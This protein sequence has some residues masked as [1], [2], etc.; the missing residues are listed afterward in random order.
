MITKQEAAKCVAAISE[1]FDEANKLYDSMRDAYR[2][3]VGGRVK[4]IYEKGVTD[5]EMYNSLAGLSLGSFAQCY[6]LEGKTVIHLRSNNDVN[7]WLF[8]NGDIKF[9]VRWGYG[10]NDLSIDSVIPIDGVIY[11][12]RVSFIERTFN[13][14]LTSEATRKPSD[15]EKLVL[16]LDRVNRFHDM[17]V[18]YAEILN[19]ADAVLTLFEN[20]AA[21]KDEKRDELILKTFGIEPELPKTA[22][23]R[24][25]IIVEEVK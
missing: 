23:R 11:G 20:I 5:T 7:V 1:R 17:T 19:D 15:S 14:A 8:S 12:R 24:F 3:V 18:R 21:K 6:A 22:T 10:F 16:W 2:R 4:A 25:N 13:D 9:R